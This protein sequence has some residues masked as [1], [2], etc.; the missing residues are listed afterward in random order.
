MASPYSKGS[1]Q[2]WGSPESY[3]GVWGIL[4]HL[5]P[6]VQAYLWT[7]SFIGRISLVYTQG[8][9]DLGSCG[10]VRPQSWRLEGVRIWKLSRT[11]SGEKPPSFSVLTHRCILATR[12][13][14]GHLLV[15]F[16]ILVRIG[17]PYE[18]RWSTQFHLSRNYGTIFNPRFLINMKRNKDI[19]LTID[20]TRRSTKSESIKQLI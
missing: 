16:C 5:S 12:K 9:H 17:A 15:I 11:Y 10:V 20:K 7:T 3:S 18:G 2:G 14:T 6:P 1:A 19:K 13:P 4:V 8:R